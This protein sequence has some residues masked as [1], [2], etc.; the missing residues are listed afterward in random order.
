MNQRRQGWVGGKEGQRAGR[1][2][3]IG[4]EGVDSVPLSYSWQ[5]SYWGKKEAPLIF[6]KD[7]HPQMIV[8]IHGHVTMEGSRGHMVPHFKALS[9]GMDSING[10]REEKKSILYRLIHAKNE[11][12]SLGSLARVLGS[13]LL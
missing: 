13:V 7:P 4:S 5:T 1:G 3:V 9:T 10:R 12:G 11:C 8:D 2:L 6:V